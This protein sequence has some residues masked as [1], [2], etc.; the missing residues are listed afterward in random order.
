MIGDVVKLRKAG[1]VSPEVVEVVKEK[2]DGS[3]KEFVMPTCCPVCGAPL[4]KI[5]ALHFCLNPHCDAKKIEQIIHFA[6][7][8][9]M[10][11]EGLGEKV[12]EQLFNLGFVKNIA[13]LYSLFE[14]RDEIIALEGWQAKSVDNLLEAIEKSKANSL[15]RVLFGFGIKEVGEKMAKTLSRKFYTIDS[16]SS[17]DEESLLE[18]PDVGPT[19][20]KSLTTWF[21]DEE[22]KALIETLKSK[23]Q[24]FEFK[25]VTAVAANS[26]FSGKICVL[27]GTLSSMGR[28]QAT[29]ILENLGAKV[30]GSVSKATDIVIAGEEAGSKLDK[31]HELGIMVLD[32][33]EFLKLSK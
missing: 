18:I 21:N 32:E 33:E 3:Q 2:R 28:K 13:D 24:N 14:H 16:L 25:G 8:D 5:D 19:V 6:S 9:A 26:F 4:S 11:I 12:A 23:G 30:T 10:D 20:A 29:E 22:N 31:A 7:K 27:T 17:Q 15:E 1:D